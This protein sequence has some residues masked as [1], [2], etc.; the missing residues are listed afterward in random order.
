M[1]C[2]RDISYDDFLNQKPPK[3][4]L[5][6]HI[7]T[8]NQ[9]FMFG[10][11]LGS[12]LGLIKEDIDQLPMGKALALLELWLNTPT[13]SRRQLLEELRKDPDKQD[14]ADDYDQY[15]T[16]I[17]ADCEQSTE[18]VKG[19]ADR[20]S[21]VSGKEEPS[22][23]EERMKNK[24]ETLEAT[25][26][27]QEDELLVVIQR[28]EEEKI[29]IKEEMQLAIKGK[30][31]ELNSEIHDLQVRINNNEENI[32]AANKELESTKQELAKEKEKVATLVQGTI[33]HERFKELSESQLQEIKVENESV[34][35][36]LQENLSTANEELLFTKQLLSN[37][38]EEL[39]AQRDSM[40]LQQKMTKNM[41][42]E[43]DDLRAKLASKDQHTIIVIESGKFEVRLTSLSSEQCPNLLTKI[44]DKH[45]HVY[46]SDSSSDV[47]Q[48]LLVPLLQT[49][50]ISSLY[51]R[52]THLKCD[53]V[54]SFSSQISDNNTVESLYINQNSID[55]DG[56]IILAESLK[57]NK[58][59]QHLSL[60]FNTGITSVSVPSLA[61]FIC[62][63]STL[64][65]LNVS[66]TSIDTEGVLE[67]AKSLKSNERLEKIVVD[68]KHKAVCTPLLLGTRLAYSYHSVPHEQSGTVKK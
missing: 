52:S 27:E 14:V 37:K 57:N 51:I 41:H 55:D 56:V 17:F 33:D 35:K 7:D 66:N 65:V 59:L 43:I 67:L 10:L 39:K 11:I 22:N 16:N 4:E 12:M 50:K 46:L 21:F 34:I 40:D 42:R 31:N 24:I 23:A 15:L 68:E 32:A 19:H 60:E 2:N 8:K 58:K 28:K 29:A 6:Q 48:L 54:K 61:E 36:T 53:F 49:K 44:E 5:I 18:L 13:A 1:A 3:E 30:E 64:S 63:N 45:Q 26:K 9:W 62:I 20:K 25:L 38:E 47:A